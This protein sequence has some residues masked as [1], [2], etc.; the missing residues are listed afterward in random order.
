MRRI[1]TLNE[2]VVRKK[3]F[4]NGSPNFTPVIS[5]DNMAI[6]RQKYRRNIVLTATMQR[7]ISH[8]DPLTTE[9]TQL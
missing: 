2:F 8:H 7:I 6:I 3:V 1:S 5:V 9:G 4:N